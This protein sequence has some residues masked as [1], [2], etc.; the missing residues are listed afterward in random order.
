MNEV[1]IH[2]FAV[3]VF[4]IGISLKSSTFY[5][6]VKKD[7]IIHSTPTNVEIALLED[8]VLVEVH[9]QK[10][11]NNFSVGDIFLGKVT[12]TM[13]GLNAAFVD[14]GY[15]KDAF[16]HYTDLG[17]KLKSLLRFTTGAISGGIPA[18]LD[19]FRIDPDIQKGGKIDNIFQRKESV[20]VQILKEPISSKGSRLSC[21]ITLPGRYLVLSPFQNNI[22][23]SKKITNAEE[24]QRLHSLIESIRPKNFGVILRTAAEGKK[25]ADLHEEITELMTRWNE[26]H[27]QLHNKHQPVK[28]LSELDKTTSILRDLLNDDFNRI[29]VNDRELYMSI[30]GYLQQIAPDKVNIVQAHSDIRPIFDAFGVTKQIKSSFSKTAGM[31][32][33]AYLVIER[34]EAMHVIDVNSGHKGGGADQETQTIAVNLEA[35]KEAARQIRLRDIGGIIIIDFIDMRNAEHR[36]KL[37][38]AMQQFMSTDK[39][40]HTILPLSKFGL[41]QIT[42]ERVRPEV[43]IDT[44]EKCPTCNGTGKGNASI[45]VGDN[46]VRDANFILKSQP[47]TQFSIVAHP[48]LEAFL[49]KGSW[50]FG[51]RSI[52]AEWLWKYRKHIKITSNNEFGLS[53][54][55]FFDKN[56]DE[57]RL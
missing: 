6:P 4:T 28:L 24:R 33:G 34:T 16:L 2:S 7:L 47:T 19:A 55:K 36:K 53:Q 54:Y 41:M 40:Q 50:V 30:R 35:A 43:T 21:E 42:R 32:S 56:N 29:V 12:R 15:G 23:V 5:Q 45:L 37:L 48:F 14:I 20:L 17:P 27:K 3:L 18:S 51:Q 46:I 8:D 9:H 38:D 10:T 39:A 26:V 13:P 57:I 52:Q 11:N 49:K 1:L 25:V 44:S 31:A 22:A